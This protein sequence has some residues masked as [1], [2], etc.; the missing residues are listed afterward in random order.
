MKHEQLSLE[1]RYEDILSD[2]E[3]LV[4][5]LV[6]YLKSSVD[7]FT[8]DLSIKFSTDKETEIVVRV[9]DV[10]DRLENFGYESQVK[11]IYKLID[12]YHFLYDS[13]EE[14]KDNLSLNKTSERLEND[15]NTTLSLLTDIRTDEEEDKVE[16]KQRYTK[17]LNNFVC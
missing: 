6:Q 12:Y 7:K 16:F 15:F 8:E 14:E 2:E 3:N 13:S 5:D 17:I 11:K 9:E 4:H 10:L 1:E